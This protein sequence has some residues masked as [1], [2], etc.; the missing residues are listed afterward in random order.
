M[1]QSPSNLIVSIFFVQALIV[2]QG[3]E[4]N[5]LNTQQLQELRFPF[6]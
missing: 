2:E 5:G 3:M 6:F 4:V 1:D